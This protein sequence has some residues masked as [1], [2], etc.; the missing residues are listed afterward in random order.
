P[1]PVPTEE[2]TPEP[3]EEPTP[4]PT[5]EPTPEP[6]E[7]PTPEPTEEPTPVPT[8]EPTPE[9]TEEPTPEPTEEPTPVPTEEP[10]PEPTEEPTPV[11]TEEPTPVPTEE[12]TPV[13]TEEPTPEPTEEPTPAPPDTTLDSWPAAL[14]FET[15]A[16]FAFSAD[17]P[18]A[19]FECSLNGAPFTGCASPHILTGLAV[20]THTFA[21]RAVDPVG[22]ADPSSATYT[23]QIAPAPDC[24]SP[25]IVTASADAW[26]DQN[27]S[28]SNKGT[29]SILKVQGKSS[30]NNMRGLVRF[31]LPPMPEGCMVQSATLR[32]FAA[33]WKNSRTL[34][35]L[36]VTGAWTENG[37]TWAN[38]PA[39]SGA[40]ATATSGSGW[41]QWNVAGLVQEMYAIANQGF[42]IRDATENSGSHE[43]Q[44]HAREKGQNI[45]Q[46]VIQFGP[47]VTAALLYA[48]T[49]EADNTGEA[50]TDANLS[51]R[52]YLPMIQRTRHDLLVG[53]ND[54]GA[55]GASPDG[56]QQGRV[57]LPMVAH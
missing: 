8:E 31:N 51:D 38:Q 16:T 25:V 46:L 47:A 12:P 37:V 11:P 29:D 9:P 55:A 24:G 56:G 15:S 30:N 44:F 57:Y 41:R 17:K 54:A 5:E 28:S 50:P 48:E 43:Q 10:T 6:T 4:E 45:P 20:G 53:A 21:V 42:L 32:L 18:D 33:S 39:T 19:T 7:E 1:T 49:P 40:P 52:V 35:A 14:T 23:W 26:I 27:S 13:P 22:G 3:T 36:R 34:Q 2:P